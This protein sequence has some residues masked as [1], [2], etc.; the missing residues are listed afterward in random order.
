MIRACCAVAASVG[1][2]VA[3]AGCGGTP[4]GRPGIDGEQEVRIDISLSRFSPDVI[5][6][7][8]GTT[9]RFVVTNSDPIEHEFIAGDADLHA[10]HENGTEPSHGD[11]PGE[12]TIGI[13]ATASTRLTFAEVGDVVFACHLPGH[14][15]YGMKGIIRVR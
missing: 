15:A 3:L 13:G 11:R 9:V 7:R 14:F 1:V 6:V 8:R 10:R 12:V 4:T 2:L 5:E